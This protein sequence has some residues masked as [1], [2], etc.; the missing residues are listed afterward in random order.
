MTD[1]ELELIST[2]ERWKMT[3]DEFNEK[4]IVEKFNLL[5]SDGKYLYSIKSDDYN[6]SPF[7]VYSLFGFFVIEH[8]SSYL[9]RYI[10]ATA[11]KPEFAQEKHE[12][13]LENK[14]KKRKKIIK[15]IEWS[16]FIIL[17]VVLPAYVLIRAL[18]SNW[19]NES[20]IENYIG[21]YF[22]HLFHFVGH[23]LILMMEFIYLLLFINFMLMVVVGIP[24]FLFLFV[25]DLI[26]K[27]GKSKQWLYHFFK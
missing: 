17:F 2:L 26:I 14:K 7:L 5:C 8:H 18:G 6:H 9:R 24:T 16:V 25:K 21:T 27:E 23:Y 1:K 4:S 3:A 22:D 11:S 13:E 15:T 20:D 12:K 10:S 19:T